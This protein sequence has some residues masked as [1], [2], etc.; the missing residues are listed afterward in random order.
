MSQDWAGRNIF[1]INCHKY[2]KNVNSMKIAP[3]P[4]TRALPNFPTRFW[5]KLG[6]I[7]AS[8]RFFWSSLIKNSK[9]LSLSGLKTKLLTTGHQNL[10]YSG[11]SYFTYD[12][13]TR[14][15]SYIVVSLR[16]IP[17]YQIL[18]LIHCYYIS[19]RWRGA[20][21]SISFLELLNSKVA[22]CDCMAI[23]VTQYTTS[24]RSRNKKKQSGISTVFQT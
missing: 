6:K 11:H 3:Y 24:I 10:W 19:K 4:N 17:V 13:L 15:G 16:G 20:F 7:L 1:D 21:F 12:G 18:S 5:G 22:W 8:S 14:C 23:L 9:W 2:F